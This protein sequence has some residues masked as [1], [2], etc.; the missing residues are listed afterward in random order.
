MS[1][2][3]DSLILIP[4]LLG[5][6]LLTAQP[7]AASSG[8]LTGELGRWLDTQV[9]PEL[10]ATL[11]KHP[12]F[13]GETIR[14]VT[15]S[16]GKPTDQTSRLH[17]AVEAHLTQQLLKHSGVRIAWGNSR[18]N[19]CNVMEDPVYLLGVEIE[20]D[21]AR[22]HKLNIGMID[23]AES[24]WVSGVNHSW[25]GRLTATESA[26]LGQPVTG[27]P[28][29]SVDSPLPVQ[30][31]RDIARLMREHLSCAHPEG[32]NGP[33]YLAPGVTTDESR[34]L[35]SLKSELATTPI[36]ALTNAK[37]DADWVL[38]LMASDAGTPGPVQQFALL[39]ADADGNAAQ[40]VATVYV[41][42]ARRSQRSAPPTE[43]IAGSY[44]PALPALLSGFRV[45]PAERAGICDSSQARS[46]E[47]AEVS[48][49]L[50]SSAYLFVLSSSARRLKSTSCDA[51]LVEASAGERRYRLRIPPSLDDRPDA[52]LYAIAVRD[53]GAAR[54]LSRHIRTGVCTRPLNRTDRWLTEL[55]EL[56]ERHGDAIEWRAIHLNHTPDG[57]AQL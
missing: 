4:L 57:V 42:G 14:L 48:F 13:K 46:R 29:G 56:L 21:G 51:R 32:L 37:D 20:G 49:D 38:N 3:P 53:R 18:S 55:D 27:A 36:V 47:C 31:S 8:L 39:L 24:V 26:A 9:L 15:L 45:E 41:S 30:A 10:S 22:Y 16:G 2:L 11:G 50:M 19:S 34:V 12:R 43:T 40:Q 6:L 35:A 5:A 23:L 33:V 7:A 25:R 17:Q 44:S 1:R 52:G 28:S 54:E